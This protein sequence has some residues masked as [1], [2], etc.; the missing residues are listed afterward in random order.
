M[1]TTDPY[2]LRKA[3]KGIVGEADSLKLTLPSALRT[4][5]MDAVRMES[6]VG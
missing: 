2:K 5:A 4:K 3:C 1:K 6:K